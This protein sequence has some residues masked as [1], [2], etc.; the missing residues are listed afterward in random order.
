MR[1]ENRKNYKHRRRQ[2]CYSCGWAGGGEGKTLKFGD[3]LFI[4]L[5]D[6]GEI[7]KEH[8]SADWK[9]MK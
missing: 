6:L 8:T 9:K 1:S 3:L 4:S 2:S 5:M 7:R